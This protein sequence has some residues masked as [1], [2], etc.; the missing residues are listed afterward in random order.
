MPKGKRSSNGVQSVAYSNGKA[1]G[2]HVAKS[3]QLSYQSSKVDGSKYRASAAKS[4][5]RKGR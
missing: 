5:L 2:P 1:S 3:G 4:M